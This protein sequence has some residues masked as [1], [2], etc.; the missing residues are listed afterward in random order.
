[1]WITTGGRNGSF[2]ER[3]LRKD[4]WAEMRC[5]AAVSVCHRSREM[6]AIG[7]VIIDEGIF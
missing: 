5:G 2:Q 6:K 7:K 1:M 4:I 3:W